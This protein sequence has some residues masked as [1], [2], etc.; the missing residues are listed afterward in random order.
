MTTPYKVCEKAVID[1][2]V[3]GHPGEKGRV[4]TLLQ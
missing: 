1:F 4:M 2:A 3:P